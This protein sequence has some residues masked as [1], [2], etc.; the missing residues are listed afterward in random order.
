MQLDVGHFFSWKRTPEG[1]A[2]PEMLV[3][4]SWVMQGYQ[5]VQ[6]DVANLSHRDLIFAQGLFDK[7]SYQ[8]HERETPIIRSFISANIRATDGDHLTP[9]AYV[10]REL[11]G[12]RFP[13]RENGQ[14]MWRVGVVGVTELPD[15]STG[16]L[17]G[18][19]VDDPLVASRRAILEAR[20]QCDLLVVLAYVSEE[21]AFKL[22]DLNPEVDIVIAPRARWGRTYQ[23][24][25]GWLVYADP[26]TKLLGELR[27]Y[28]DDAGRVSR[29]SNRHI[30]LDDRIP[31]DP[32]IEQL[33]R[34]AREQIAAA[35]K[36]W[37]SRQPA[38]WVNVPK[39]PL[40]AGL[41]VSA[42]TCG[43]C[44]QAELAV[45]SQSAH[46]RAFAALEKRNQHFESKCLS[47][48]TTG[49]E[50]GGFQQV[51][52]TPHL[53]NVQCE[54][55]HGPGQ[56]HIADPMKPYGQVL[57]PH[58]CLTCHTR[59]DSPAFDFADYWAKIQH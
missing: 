30:M 57:T 18:L 36:A 47:C 14:R 56:E 15:L 5:T 46:A 13:L 51:H 54:T 43:A 25:H 26:Q 9:P 41:F 7:A 23:G 32:A 11:T 35:V 19:T 20:G 44:H 38:S 8:A 33:V 58:A 10:I 48:H 27:I 34:T 28:V 12:D 6:H 1:A 49:Y 52:L 21:T 24:K 37:L 45:W 53:T 29:V 2:T 16:R 40:A 4:N 3:R 17:T 59:A 31:G 42:Q 55:C 50:S 22:M 39:V